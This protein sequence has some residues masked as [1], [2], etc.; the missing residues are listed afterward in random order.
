[1]FVPDRSRL[2]LLPI[3]LPQAEA[4]PPRSLATRKPQR[5]TVTVPW[6]L[7]QFLLDCSDLEGRSVSNLACFWMEQQAH[8]IR[9]Q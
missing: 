3:Q 6:W 5:I 8:Q 4:L 2:S 9:G 7:Y 1:M